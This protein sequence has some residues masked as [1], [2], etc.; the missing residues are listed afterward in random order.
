[1]EG[2]FP[3]PE[4]ASIKKTLAFKETC[5]ELGLVRKHAP[6]Y[7]EVRFRYTMLLAKFFEENEQV[8][9]TYF[10]GIAARLGIFSYFGNHHQ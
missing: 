2:S 4:K 7:L 6:K 5:E 1:M 9:F 10:S 3:L 8:L